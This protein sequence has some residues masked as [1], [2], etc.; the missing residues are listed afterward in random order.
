[1]VM[2]YADLYFPH[3]AQGL[4][5]RIGR[6]ISLPDIEAQL[7]P[8]NY[9]YSHSLLYTYDAYTQTGVNLTFKLSDHWLYQIARFPQTNG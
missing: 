8:K 9:T 1:M 4:N 6:Y 5:V 7:A 3:V 2:A